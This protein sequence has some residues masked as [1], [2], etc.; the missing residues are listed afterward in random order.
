M[1]NRSLSFDTQKQKCDTA[2]L[3]IL[4]HLRCICLRVYYKLPV[5]SHAPVI[6]CF[7]WYFTLS[8]SGDKVCPVTGNTRGKVIAWLLQQH[9]N[10]SKNFWI[11]K[12]EIE[13][14]RNEKIQWTILKL[15]TF[16]I[17][18]IK[19]IQPIY[20]GLRISYNLKKSVSMNILI[21]KKLKCR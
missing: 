10:S 2:F 13:I 11:L 6:N 20:E 8:R 5:I 16:Q 17:R 18:A 3:G 12:K 7:P 14:N 4:T 21:Y 15:K 9:Q 1:V 19:L